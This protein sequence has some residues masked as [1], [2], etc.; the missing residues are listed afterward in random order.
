M[1]SHYNTFGYDLISGY[2]A[3]EYIVRGK[4]TEKAD[5]F[6]FG[7]V[8]IEVVTGTRNNAFSQN[9]QSILQRVCLFL[10]SVVT[11]L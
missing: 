4:L 2:M 10:C 1:I 6:S 9:S 11:G 3:P 5:V 7:I 8:V